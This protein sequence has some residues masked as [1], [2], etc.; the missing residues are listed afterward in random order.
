MFHITHSSF[1]QLFDSQFDPLC[2]FLVYYTT[3]HMVIE[4]VVQD[5]FVKLWEE[6]NILQIGSIKTYLFT[7]ARNRMLNRLRDEKRRYTLFEQ[8]VQHEVE[9]GHGE[10]CFDIDEFVQIVQSA[11]DTLPEKCR[12]IFDLSKKEK[13]TYKQIAERLD[14]SIKTVENQMGIALRKIREHLSLFYPRIGSTLFLIICDLFPE[15][16]EIN[17]SGR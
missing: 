15:Y 16:L 6:R 10:E 3:D 8:W 12:I 17:S 11:I 13:L 5:V 1:R 7:S 14:L 2:R 4:E 9:K